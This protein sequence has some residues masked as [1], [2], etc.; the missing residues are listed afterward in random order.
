MGIE[1]FVD[2]LQGRGHRE[3]DRHRVVDG[4]VRLLSRAE[5]M[6][7]LRAVWNDTAQVRC[8]GGR[9]P[10]IIAR[11]DRKDLFEQQV[12]STDR[13]PA[14]KHR[15][16][17]R[18]SRHAF[19]F[20]A[21]RRGGSAFGAKAARPAAHPRTRNH[22]LKARRAVRRRNNLLPVGRSVGR[23]ARVVVGIIPGKTLVLNSKHRY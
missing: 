1:P 12:I 4:R 11:G 15:A 20:P 6:E 2:G 22:H 13:L 16:P 8:A 14:L 3:A 19:P 7:A 21:S 10:G 5:D 9:R 17:P 23:D 18:G